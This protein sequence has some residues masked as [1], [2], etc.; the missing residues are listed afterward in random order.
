MRQ[1]VLGNNGSS[2]AKTNWL[3]TTC[4]VPLLNLYFNNYLTNNLFILGSFVI[5]LWKILHDIPVVAE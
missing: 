1:L 3:Q 2:S 4:C 5:F